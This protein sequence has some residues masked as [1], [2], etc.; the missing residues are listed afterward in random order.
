MSHGLLA[1]DGSPKAAEAL[2]LGAYLA[3]KW[4][5][6]LSVVTALEDSKTRENPLDKAR[7]YLE[8]RGIQADY[9]SQI[10]SPGEVVL[11]TQ[12]QTGCDFLIVGGYGYQ[13]VMELIFG[14]TLD[15][16]LRQSCVPVLICH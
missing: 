5:I 7:E 14:S 1:F 6:Q 15:A 3:D 8:A 4:G 11:E 9:Y 12:S 2:Y 13:P 10:G 16:L